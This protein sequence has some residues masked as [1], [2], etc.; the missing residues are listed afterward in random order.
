MSIW[1]AEMRVDLDLVVIRSSTGSG[2]KGG[3]PSK[4]ASDPGVEQQR[5]KTES[6]RL[7][8]SSRGVLA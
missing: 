7:P 4:L 8:V 3:R 2:E 1:Q 6:A 5:M